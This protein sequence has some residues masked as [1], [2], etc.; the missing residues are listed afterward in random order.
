MVPYWYFVWM[1][2]LVKTEVANPVW[3]RPLI[4]WAHFRPFLAPPPPREHPW[5]FRYPP[6]KIRGAFSNFCP[7]LP[8]HPPKKGGKNH[9]HKLLFK[10]LKK[11]IYVCCGFKNFSQYLLLYYSLRNPPKSLH[12]TVWRQILSFQYAH[13][14]ISDIPPPPREHPWAFYYPLPPS[15]MLT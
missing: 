14:S 8:P 9:K 6:L 11:L 13:V 7:P 12:F 5:A 10:A 3:G 2:S 15:A 1:I 4:T